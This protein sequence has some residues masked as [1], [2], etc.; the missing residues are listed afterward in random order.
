MRKLLLGSIAFTVLIAGPAM[1]ADMPVKAP[2]YKA[3]PPP[4]AFA[5]T[6]FYLGVHGGC[7]WANTPNPT[8]YAVDTFED[9]GAFTTEQANGCFGGGQIGYNYQ[10]PNRV[11]LGIEADAAWANI[12]SSFSWNQPPGDPFGDVNSWESKLTS[13]GTVRGRVG[14]ALDQFL[15]YVTGGFAWGRNRLSST[16]P[17]SCDNPFAPFPAP[18]IDPQTTTATNTHYGWVLGAGLE[19]AMNQNWSLKGEYLHLDLGVQRYNVQVDYDFGV[20]PGADFGRLRIDTIKLGV[21]YRFG[22]GP[23]VAKY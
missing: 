5:W 21:N 19:Y 12:R 3:P 14:Y 23:V 8:N 6:G 16:C 7:G 13:F 10:L 18:D 2:V 11:V 1:A 20:P 15:P 17:S 9:L 4:A 22:S